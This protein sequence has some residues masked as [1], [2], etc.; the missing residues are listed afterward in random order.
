MADM[1][2]VLRASR[3]LTPEPLT[4]AW[5]M[6]QDRTVVDVGQ[7]PHPAADEVV[8]LGQQTVTPGF[9]DIHAHGGGGVAY[10]DGAQAAHSVLAT[11]RQH[12]TTSAMASLVT[13]TIE[14]LASQVTALAPLVKDDELLGIHLE[15]PWL[16]EHHRG[17]HDP[18]LL[19]DPSADDITRLLQVAEGTIRM[20]TLAVEREGGLAAV[21]QLAGAGVIVAPGHSHATYQEARQ[22]I[23]AGARVATHLFNAERGIHHREPGLIPALMEDDRVVVELI[24]DGVHVHPTIVRDVA[25]LKPGRHVLVTDAMAAAGSEDGDYLLGPLAVEVR[26]GIARLAGGGAIAGSTLTLDRAIRFCV[27]QAGL[28]LVDVVRAATLTP[29]DVVG[30]PDLGRI[31]P[32]ARADLVVLDEAL[33]VQRVLR[34]GQWVA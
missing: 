14:N 12:G 23:E 4:D 27:E 10:T 16:S 19:Q 13:D 29:A 30:R 1:R 34:A 33:Y 32:G 7:G 17:A 25:L 5:V 24:A 18:E 21:F 20:V 11:H 9:V 28:D 22:A 2:T 26:D 3:I 8:D 6:V 15:G 31:E